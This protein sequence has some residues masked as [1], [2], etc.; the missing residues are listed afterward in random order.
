MI[1]HAAG[2][3]AQQFPL[4]E[5]TPA[6]SGAATIYHTGFLAI[7]RQEDCDAGRKLDKLATRL[8]AAAYRG[9]VLLIQRKLGEGRYEY[10]SVPVIRLGGAA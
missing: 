1:R 2:Q 3:S 5:D 4:S 6:A 10:L 8:L 7:D 9:E